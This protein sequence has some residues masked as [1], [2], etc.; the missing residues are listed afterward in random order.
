MPTSELP[1]DGALRVQLTEDFV[2]DGGTWTLAEDQKGQ[3]VARITPP[4]TPMFQQIVT[5]LEAKPV[6]PS[7]L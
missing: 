3:P 7:G 2:L 4:A 1:S 6:P 5:Y